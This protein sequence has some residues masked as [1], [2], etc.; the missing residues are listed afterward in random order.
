MKKIEATWR[1]VD[2]SYEVGKVPTPEAMLMKAENEDKLPRY[3]GASYYIK[4]IEILRHD[5][6]FTWVG[7]VDWFRQ[8]R[9]PFSMSSIQSAYW[10]E[11]Q[12]K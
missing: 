5:K 7:V 6:G 3:I 1:D 9:L 10:K 8:K 4:T 11:Q 2:V 12:R